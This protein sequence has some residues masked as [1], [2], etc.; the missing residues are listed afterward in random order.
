ML[1]TGS[2]AADPVDSIGRARHEN[3]KKVLT[4]LQ[5]H[6]PSPRDAPLTI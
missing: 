1:S 5:L 3:G 2:L 6:I 4:R